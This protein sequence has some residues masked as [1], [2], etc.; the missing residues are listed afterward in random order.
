MGT[1]S[2]FPCKKFTRIIPNNRWPGLPPGR[3]THFAFQYS[4]L[5]HHPFVALDHW[6]KRAKLPLREVLS[7][8]MIFP[9]DCKKESLY[10][11]SGYDYTII[12]G[13][14]LRRCMG[15]ECII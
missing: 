3:K 7:V 6:I 8:L 12:T 14:Y 5:R 2:P 13:R 11:Q 4:L 15:Y 9:I 1:E 10:K